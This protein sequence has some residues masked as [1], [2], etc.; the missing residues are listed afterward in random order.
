MKILALAGTY[1]H[2]GHLFS[3]VFNEK[4]VV[5][6]RDL[7]D[8]V[9][10]LAPRPYVPPGF[11][12]L[13]RWKSY[14][15]IK[16]YEIRNGVAVYRPATPVIPRVGAALWVDLAP[17]LLCRALARRLHRRTKFDAIISFD[18]EQAG[19]LAWRIGKDLGIPT[20]GWAF[21]NDIRHPRVSPL[22][23]MVA[24]AI[25][26]LDVVFY[27][28]RELLE[29]A[30]ELLM[31]SPD[32][33]PTNRHVILPHGI[34]PPPPLPR[35][36]VRDRIRKEWDIPEGQ[37]VVLYTGRIFH[38]KGLFELLEAVSLAAAQDSRITCIV[39]GSH[40]AYDETGALHKKLDETPLLK[41]RIRLLPGCGPDRIWE[42]LC[43]ADIFAFT[44]HKEG[45]PNSLL[46]AMA[47]GVPAIAFAI[48]PV[49]EIDA[50]AGALVTVTPFDSELFG[51]AILRLAA[52]PEERARIG[53]K[54]RAL[55][56]DRFMVK[57]NMAT[58]LE[59]LAQV[60]KKQKLLRRSGH[61]V[62][63]AAPGHLI[64]KEK[65]KLP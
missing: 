13:P 9:E 23:K 20:A 41:E 38:E 62:N 51:Q 6:L 2:P 11:T 48:P 31:R 43:G 29:K 8:Y 50:G 36:E 44:S 46:E 61:R 3:G 57:K 18:L 21:G 25:E 19:G 65:R 45:M 40:P 5:A 16:G 64:V 32:L 30:A 28:S 49:L 55:V 42:Y 35:E 26:R 14:G 47:M 4:C 60:V 15:A 10:V 27:Q 52:S 53:A 12:F 34:P 33:M 24:R 17:F 59:R 58:A 1:P 22:G 7:C 37:A 39:V 63:I 54:G 56:M